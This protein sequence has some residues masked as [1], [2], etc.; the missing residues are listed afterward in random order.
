M[1]LF[2]RKNSPTDKKNLEAIYNRYYTDF[3]SFDNQKRKRESK[4][5]VSIDIEKIADD[6]DVD[7]DIIFGR[8]YY[9]LDYKYGYTNE[10]G[11][12][13]HFFALK[14]GKDKHCINFPYLASVLARL[15]SQNRKFLVTQAIAI[16]ALIVSIVSW[17]I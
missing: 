7:Q 10:N 9:H 6:L 3:S 15:R 11:T 14:I 13:V 2:R 12:K 5:Y 8:L 1:N 16:V 17:F 4:I